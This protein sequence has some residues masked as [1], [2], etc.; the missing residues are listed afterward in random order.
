MFTMLKNTGAD[1]AVCGFSTSVETPKVMENTS[2]VLN[3]KELML[4]IMRDSNIYAHYA[5][6]SRLYYAKHL[7]N[8]RFSEQYSTCEDAVFSAEVLSVINN[9][10]CSNIEV[11]VYRILEDSLS[12]NRCIRF[13]DVLQAREAEIEIIEKNGWNELAIERKL[14]FKSDLLYYLLNTNDEKTRRLIKSFL[15]NIKVSVKEILCI[16]INVAN[17]MKMIIKSY[18]GILFLLIYS[19]KYR[20]DGLTIKY[21]E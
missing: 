10:V 11:Y 5:V 6:W 1:M 13:P 8:I 15:V 18:C 2:I 17:K 4:E 3:S 16:D 9:C 20:K 19:I 12:H 14:M 7:K 21:E